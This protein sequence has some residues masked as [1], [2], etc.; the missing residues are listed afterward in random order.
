MYGHG[1][2]SRPPLFST[3]VLQVD[4]R[5]QHCALVL[6]SLLLLSFLV[7]IVLIVRQPFLARR[8]PAQ[9]LSYLNTGPETERLHHLPY[10]VSMRLQTSGTNSIHTRPISSCA[11]AVS[12]PL[13]SPPRVPAAALSGGMS[14]GGPERHRCG[15]LPHHGLL[16]WVGGR[17]RRLE[18][19]AG[20]SRNATC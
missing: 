12:L 14:T 9:S 4:G 18:C 7:Y 15:L 19:E 13:S 5:D 1:L 6:W 17:A 10:I 8:L 2:S 20:D 16:E 3:P 11:S